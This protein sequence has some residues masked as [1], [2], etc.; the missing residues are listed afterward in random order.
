MGGGERGRGG[1]GERGREGERESRGARES[2]GGRGSRGSRSIFN[3]T[4]NTQHSTLNTSCN[5]LFKLAREDSIASF[6]ACRNS[7]YAPR[8]AARESIDF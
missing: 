7:G 8:V 4:L 1:E 5:T 6:A 2:R 3:S